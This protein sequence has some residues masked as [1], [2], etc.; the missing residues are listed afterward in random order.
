MNGSLQVNRLCDNRKQRGRGSRVPCL[1]AGRQSF[2]MRVFYIMGNRRLYRIERFHTL[3][4]SE[5]ERPRLPPCLRRSGFAQAG[6]NLWEAS[7]LSFAR[8]L[9]G[10][11][12]HPTAPP[13]FQ[14]VG[15]FSYCET[16]LK[17][18]GF[19]HMLLKG[20]AL[21]SLP[22]CESNELLGFLRY[23]QSPTTGGAPNQDSQ[24]DRP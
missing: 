1:P 5:S 13:P 2:R 17:G 3:G 11:A 24:G 7:R 12:A 20:R 8:P 6:L 21:R 4:T 15:F 9:P 18:P 10:K 22:Y 16:V 19:L 23:E 14:K